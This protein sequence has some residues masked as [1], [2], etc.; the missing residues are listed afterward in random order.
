MD[1]DFSHCFSNW[2]KLN[3]LNES[4]PH[5]L[6]FSQSLFL[7]LPLPCLFLTH[8]YT[9]RNIKGFSWEWLLLKV[10]TIRRKIWGS[11]KGCPSLCREQ[12]LPNLQ[13]MHLWTLS[14]ACFTLTSWSSFPQASIPPGIL[15]PLSP[16]AQDCFCDWNCIWT[17]NAEGCYLLQNAVAFQW[18]FFLERSLSLPYYLRSLLSTEGDTVLNSGILH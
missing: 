16:G 1:C 3:A 11:S 2:I 7:S 18:F 15:F 12:A 10:D 17:C 5:S 13:V 6:S 4:L 14:W 8:T 9:K